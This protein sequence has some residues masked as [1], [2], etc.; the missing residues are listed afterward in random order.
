MY[1]SEWCEGTKNV[2]LNGIVSGVLRFVTCSGLIRLVESWWFARYV[3]VINERTVDVW[4]WL[5]WS[6]VK[7]P[8]GG[9]EEEM[10][11]LKH[12]DR[13][14]AP[15]SAEWAQVRACALA[16]K[17]QLSTAKDLHG[18]HGGMFNRFANFWCSHFLFSLFFFLFSLDVCWK[19]LEAIGARGESG[20]KT[21][22]HLKLGAT[23][24]T[25]G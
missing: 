24:A 20:H 10:R 18:A 17:M 14:T 3:R 8:S 9:G 4:S 13:L 6:F 7:L 15:W 2:I 22:S 5:S 1:S 11:T 19:R 16:F 25:D 21:S 23:V 12:R